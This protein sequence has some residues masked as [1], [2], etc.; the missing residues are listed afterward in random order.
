M[1]IKQKEIMV[2]QD[3]EQI[4]PLA[5]PLRV[6]ILKILINRQATVK[7]VADELHQS[8]AKIHYHIKELEKNGFIKMVD[9]V[10]KGGILEKYYQAVAKNY[11]IE[12][13]IG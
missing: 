12:Y 1:K 5:D 11:Q 7:Q 3:L 8:S 4:K 9:T 13:R 2:L 10:E 6:K